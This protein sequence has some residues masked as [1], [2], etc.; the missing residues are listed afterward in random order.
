MKKFLITLFIIFSMFAFFG[1]ASDKVTESLD[2]IPQEY[3]EDINKVQEEFDNS[4][5][6]FDL[7]DT[8]DNIVSSNENEEEP[9]VN[10][11]SDIE[12]E[13]EEVEFLEEIEEPEVYELPEDEL[14]NNSIIE[15]YAEE[16][17]LENEELEPVS[18]NDI[19]DIIDSNISVLD[20]SEQNNNDIILSTDSDSG[21]KK[22]DTS[23]TS[24]N[25]DEVIEEVSAV[26]EESDISIDM[27]DISSDETT[28]DNVESEDFFVSR[29]VSL[30]LGEYLDLSYPGKGWIFLGSTD[31]SV[32]L[33]STEKKL[34]AKDTN[35]VLLARNAGTSVLHFYKEDIL[36]GKYLDDYIEV[37]VKPERS[38]NK[39]HI[40]APE[41]KPYQK[42]E[43]EQEIDDIINKADEFS[44][45]NDT[46]LKT[47]DE[48]SVSDNEKVKI[49]NI[50]SN[51]AETRVQDVATD[52]SV[53]TI[54]NKQSVIQNKTESTDEA[55]SNEN[56]EENKQLLSA[57]QLYEIS[58]KAFEDKRFEDS[59]NAISE[60]L[61]SS[62]KN[63]DK[64]L[65]LL[66]KIYESD[67]SLKN[68]K[69]AIETYEKLKSNYPSSS[70]W[71][72]A[73]KRIIYL[74]RFYINIR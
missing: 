31:G 70:L 74:K 40:K 19:I 73:N 69:K 26:D 56:H 1:C 27:E 49:E 9:L 35:F 8:K 60:F 17:N 34:G 22:E 13:S 38:K 66:A 24:S 15:D 7:E 45:D 36:E 39:N 2:S 43:K 65:F 5:S 11:E 58:V 67:S 55:T 57:E 12:D 59:Y 64:G 68:I 61:S 33:I 10:S 44:S 3:Q 46:E 51:K 54:K 41:Y 16:S 32:N 37:T 25:T 72:E 18:Q 29:S 47:T 23:I 28:E 62:D 20:D 30:K 50:T 53:T 71:D 6:S 48:V 63:R 4:E 14:E 42:R 21:N 52:K